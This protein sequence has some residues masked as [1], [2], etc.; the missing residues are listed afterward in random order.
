MFA[1]DTG[2]DYTEESRFDE[3]ELKKKNT[4]DKTGVKE[5]GDSYDYMIISFIKTKNV[6]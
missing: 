5:K 4:L 3:E 2:G 6:L 1:K